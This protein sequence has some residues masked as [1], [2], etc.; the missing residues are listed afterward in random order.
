LNDKE[1]ID[2]EGYDVDNYS[3]NEEEVKSIDDDDEE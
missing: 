2:D 3:E 1:S